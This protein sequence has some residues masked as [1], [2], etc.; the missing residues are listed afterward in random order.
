MPHIS[1]FLIENF[2]ALRRVEFKDLQPLNVLLG[3]NGCGKSTVFDA[4]QFIA[5][6]LQT[7]V[8]KALEARG[9]FGEVRSRGAHG[10]IAFTVK[11]RESDFGARGGAVQPLITYHL[12]IDE[13]DGQPIVSKEYCRWTRKVGTAGRPF[14]FLRME[15]GEGSVVTGEMPETDDHREPVRMESPDTLAIKAFGQLATN[16]RV[17]SLRRFIEG[18]FLSYLIPD[19]A[20]QI[21]PAGAEEHLSRT[22]E[23]LPNVIQY[24][25]ERHPKALGSILHKVSQRIPGLA[26]VDH[27]ETIDGRVALRF[28]DGPWQDPFLARYVSDGTIKMLAYLVLLND[29]EPPPL[30][31]VE[32]PENGLHP[33][34]LEVLAEE[35]RAHARGG[36]GSRPTQVF[37]S[38]HSPYFINALRPEELWVMQRERDGYAAVSRADTIRGVTEFCQEGARLGSLWYEDHFGGRG[39]PRAL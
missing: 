12:A 36:E 24:L 7:N 38:S 10:S 6:C 39:N 33:K 34:L 16:P 19:Q 28:R 2:R 8:R 17:A 14:D 9:R 11:Y 35:F 26:Q 4:F 30:L 3:P 1:S 22:G 27:Q 18:W 25:N 29:P 23:N 20:R 5:D 15:R 21:P 32:E 37:V 13:V 31:G